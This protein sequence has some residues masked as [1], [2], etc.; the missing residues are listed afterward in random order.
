[1]NIKLSIQIPLN[2]T[3]PILFTDQIKN[4]IINSQCLSYQINNNYMMLTK[5][6][7]MPVFDAITDCHSEDIH[8]YIIKYKNMLF[9]EFNNIEDIKLIESE[10][11]KI[12]ENHYMF[13]VNLYKL[14]KLHKY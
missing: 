9:L 4:E 5:I 13:I 2:Y 14:F 1:M 8:M 3:T 12:L 6:L 7:N 11:R 10:S